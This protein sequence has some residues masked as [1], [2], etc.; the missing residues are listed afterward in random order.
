MCEYLTVL[1]CCY[2]EIHMANGNRY[3]NRGRILMETRRPPIIIPMWLTGT[4]RTYPP[5]LPLFPPLNVVPQTPG[6]DKLMP[7]GRPFPYK[8]FPR[9]GVALS[10]TFGSPIPLSSIKTALNLNARRIHEDK[11]PLA[12]EQRHG[13]TGWVVRAGD[14]DREGDREE[15]ARIRSAVT[16]VLHR[17]V[18]AL[19]RRVANANP[20]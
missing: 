11:L 1:V 13:G 8:F 3:F 5:H 15:E 20:T 6:F 14:R 9:R 2:L 18:E 17:E 7:E 16:A 19:G 12:G 10:V 4:L